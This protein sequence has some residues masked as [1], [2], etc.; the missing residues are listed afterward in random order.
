MPEV[1][2][3]LIR[4]VRQ[5]TGSGMS[6]VKRALVEADGD[7]A[8]AVEQLRIQGARDVSRRAGRTSRNGFVATSLDTPRKVLLELLCETDFVAKT[9][10]FQELGERLAHL[11]AETGLLDVPSL[12]D[13]PLDGR[14]VREHLQS[15]SATLGERVEVRAAVGSSSPAAYLYLH[16]T[17][18]DLPPT[19]GVLVE[20]DRP[21]EVGALLAQQ[22][23]ASRPAY[24]SAADVP[25][26]VLEQERRVATALAEQEGRPA[27]VVPRIVEGRMR[28]FCS[29][30]VLLDQPWLRQPKHTV[31][32]V[33]RF[34]G[35]QVLRFERLQATG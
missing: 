23:A 2:T 6:D 8:A 7:V 30:V 5:I 20:L 3:T 19:I 15:A 17:S 21:S 28:S 1:T 32:E 18:T 26:E 24:L 25:G 12:L 34:E 13:A 9:P 16:R 27:D 11:A 10:A 14:S 35:V 4:E 31:A 33:L 29:E 22:V